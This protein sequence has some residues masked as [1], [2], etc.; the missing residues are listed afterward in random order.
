MKKYIFFFGFI[1]I[2]YSCG[3]NSSSD[4]GGSKKTSNDSANSAASPQSGMSAEI[5]QGLDLAAKSDC[6]TCH[7]INEALVGPAYQAVAKKY[8]PTQANIDTLAQK[9]IRGG[10]GNWGNLAMTPHPALSTSDAQTM[11]KYILSLK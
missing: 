4:T 10:T 2:I 7:K 8:P 6:F 9:I 11:V 1:G 3:N 5:Q